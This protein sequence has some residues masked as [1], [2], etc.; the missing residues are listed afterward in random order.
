MP[1]AVEVRRQHIDRTGLLH[2]LMILICCV[3]FVFQP[4]HLALDNGAIRRDHEIHVTIAIKI[5]RFDIRHPADMVQDG[6]RG[7]L[8]RALVGEQHN[9][10]H[11]LVA[12]S[13]GSKSSDDDI[14]IAIAF[15]GEHLRVGGIAY[16]RE[17]VFL[18]DRIPL[19]NPSD[20]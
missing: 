16:R 11:Q 17:D 18:P 8:H 20:R 4:P 19:V 10:S 7:E 6:H 13:Q 2:D 15:A 1:I 3:G 14:Q 12:R 5:A 9:A